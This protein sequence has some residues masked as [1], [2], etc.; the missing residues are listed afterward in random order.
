MFLFVNQIVFNGICSKSK[1]L[2][3]RS[4]K[5]TSCHTFCTSNI[6]FNGQIPWFI[7]KYQQEQQVTD[8]GTLKSKQQ[9]I[10]SSES[11]ANEEQD[12][13]Y[14]PPTVSSSIN[15]GVIRYSD[16][17]IMHSDP[18]EDLEDQELNDRML[19]KTVEIIENLKVS[20]NYK[21]VTVVNSKM[22]T[23]KDFFILLNSMDSKQHNDRILISLKHFLKKLKKEDIEISSILMAG[24]RQ[25]Y[26]SKKQ[27][28]RKE[29]K[30]SLNNGTVN[31]RFHKKYGTENTTNNFFKGK[32]KSWGML[33]FI[34]RSGEKRYLFEI[35]VMSPLQR[36]L[37]N[38]EDLYEIEGHQSA[39][40]LEELLEKSDQHVNEI[41]EEDQQESIFEGIQRR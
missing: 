40:E 1:V 18:V 37:L 13:K 32:D 30:L 28:Q 35:H 21:D 11:A 14:T 10:E 34:L 12:F 31:T 5:L 19:K 39:E 23:S 24:Y 22:K 29:R 6:R 27:R 33:N 3:R 41:G 25:D 17:I 36:S 9:V 26:L 20:L 38:F 15:Q 16:E 4:M 7:Q 8:S 2:S